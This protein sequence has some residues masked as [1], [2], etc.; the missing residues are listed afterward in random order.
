MAPHLHTELPQMNCCHQKRYPQ[1]CTAQMQGLG[2]GWK[3]RERE[4]ARPMVK[5]V[6]IIVLQLHPLLKLFF[7]VPATYCALAMQCDMLRIGPQRR[8]GFP[9]MKRLQNW[10]SVKIYI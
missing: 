3:E 7:I 1:H 6:Q 8:R 10:Q 4:G 9:T 5:W 2:V